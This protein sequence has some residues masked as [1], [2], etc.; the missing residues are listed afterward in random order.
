MDLDLH[1]CRS[2]A[3]KWRVLDE[4]GVLVHLESGTYFSLNPVGLF[5]WDRCTGGLTVRDIAEGVVA[6]FEVEAEEARGDLEEFLEALADQ[7]LIEFHQRP[8]AEAS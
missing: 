2:V 6:E 4:E 5:I 8:R 1:P 7:D 3:V